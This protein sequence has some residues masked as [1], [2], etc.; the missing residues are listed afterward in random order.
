MCYIREH[1]YRGSIMSVN[2]EVLES[3]LGD[4]VVS[5]NEQKDYIHFDKLKKND[6]FIELKKLPRRNILVEGTPYECVQF[7]H[8]LFEFEEENEYKYTDKNSYG[9]IYAVK[10]EMLMP[11]TLKEDKEKRVKF[12]RKFVEEMNEGSKLTRSAAKTRKEIDKELDQRLNYVAY[13][14]V[15][16]KGLYVTLLISEREYRNEP[17]YKKYKYTAYMDAETKRSCSK[18]DPN[19]VIKFEKGTFMRDKEG[20][21]IL[22]KSNFGLKCRRFSYKSFDRFIQ[23]IHE[24]FLK[25][26]RCVVDKVKRGYIFR[27]KKVSRIKQKRAYYGFHYFN[28]K[29]I[30]EMNHAIQ[31]VEYTLNYMVSKKLKK[32]NL[33]LEEWPDDLP[34]HSPIVAEARSELDVIDRLY[35][36]YK[37]AFESGYLSTSKGTLIVA[38]KNIRLDMLQD[39]LDKLLNTFKQDCWLIDDKSFDFTKI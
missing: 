14:Q 10:F 8:D 4:F 33:G 19:A 36:K 24:N 18:N 23:Q 37:D 34:M 11:K 39:N 29:C 20:N 22:E 27:Q 31:Y 35:K 5:G 25:C 17:V 26:Y 15:K 13:D 12:I 38:F 7:F 16:G 1:I 30:E 32:L 6:F 21:K 2:K 9:A 28:R 3:I